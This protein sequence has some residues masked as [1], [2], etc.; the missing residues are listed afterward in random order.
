MQEYKR[1]AYIEADVECSNA[2]QNMER[3]LRAACHA[4]DAK[5]DDVIKVSTCSFTVFVFRY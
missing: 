5:M 2:I 4:A 3:K 1:N